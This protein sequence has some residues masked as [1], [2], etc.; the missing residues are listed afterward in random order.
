MVLVILAVLIII[1]TMHDIRQATD[2]AGQAQVRLWV[3]VHSAGK[4]KQ[5]LV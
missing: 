5:D 4:A 3:V 1:L 2:M